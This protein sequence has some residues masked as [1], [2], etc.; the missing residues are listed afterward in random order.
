LP[1]ADPEGNTVEVYLDTPWQVRQPHGD[2]LDLERGD[3]ELWAETERI[4]RADP[5][6]ESAEEW[7]AKFEA[8]QHALRAAAG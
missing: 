8:R 2:P 4:C 3:A 1:R 5:S 7:A 6:F